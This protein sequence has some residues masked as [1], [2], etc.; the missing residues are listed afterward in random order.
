M[1]VARRT[2]LVSGLVCGI[3]GILGVLVAILLP[4]RAWTDL[5]FPAGGG[6]ADPPASAAFLA[7]AGQFAAA[8][9]YIFAL[10]A[11]GVA[12]GAL[13]HVRRHSA[14]GHSILLV[15]AAALM[16][17]TP[18]TTLSVGLLFWPSALLALLC[19]V[20]SIL[21]REARGVPP[22]AAH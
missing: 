6:T 10:L 5:A 17:A 1:R 19:G 8:L 18:A 7:A 20:A 13:L 21:P 14:R 12:V 22:V 15:A 11:T 16:L 9:L 2:E 3:A 4:M